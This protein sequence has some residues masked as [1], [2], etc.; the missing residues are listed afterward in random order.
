[1]T[2]GIAKSAPTSAP[3]SAPQEDIK[4]REPAKSSVGGILWEGVPISL[5]R[6]FNTD[7]GTADNRSISQMK[8]IF[9]WAKRD[10]GDNGDI[11]QKLRKIEL[12]LGASGYGET[13]QSRVFNYVK[14]QQQIDDLTKQRD[15]LRR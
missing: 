5:Y 14:I 12:K 11:L 7:V 10:V 13:R 8:D 3:D 4:P 15:S 2:E 1:M 6:Y 9:E